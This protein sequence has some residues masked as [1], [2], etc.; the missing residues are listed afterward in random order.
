MRIKSLSYNDGFDCRI[1]WRMTDICNYSCPYCA[2]GNFLSAYSA[3]K[4]ASENAALASTAEKI[5]A[6]LSKSGFKKVKIDLIGGEVSLLDLES[7]LSRITAENVA[8]YNI[9]TNLSKPADFYI[10]LAS[11]FPVS[12]TASL[13]ESEADFDV[14]FAKAERIK[15][16]GALKEGKKLGR[17]KGRKQSRY[18]LT[19]KG[20][21]IRRAR[22]EGKS[23]SEIARSLGVT[24]ITLD[25]YIKIQRIC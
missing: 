8:E 14:F 17:P 3:E 2:R 13:H 20:G 12:M 6:L 21:V 23:K 25:R 22:L 7:I 15:A 18:K 16:S 4:I 19:G 1:K 24:W 9:T 11:K 5:S 10:S